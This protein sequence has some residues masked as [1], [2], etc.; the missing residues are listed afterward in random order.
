[1]IV[2]NKLYYNH[3]TSPYRIATGIV[4]KKIYVLIAIVLFCYSLL[5]ENQIVD[6]IEACEKVTP[7]EKRYIRIKCAVLNNVQIIHIENSIAN[8]INIEDNM[9][10]TSKNDKELHGFGLTNIRRALKHY[11]ADITMTCEDNKFVLE[12][13]FSTITS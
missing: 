7:K 4:P 8:D 13:G 6:P 9:I 10:K 1:M 11:N 5:L 3:D 2:I 12:I